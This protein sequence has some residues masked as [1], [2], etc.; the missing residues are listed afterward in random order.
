MPLEYNKLISFPSWDD[1][2]LSSSLLFLFLGLVT[3]L[4]D[5]TDKLGQSGNSQTCLGF[6]FAHA[7]RWWRSQTSFDHFKIMCSRLLV[8][9]SFCLCELLHG[10][11]DF[12]E[13]SSAETERNPQS[14]QLPGKASRG[15]FSNESTK[16]SPCLNLQ[17]MLG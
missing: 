5:C 2:T 1:N 17:A 7:L 11:W 4:A 15:Y 6:P 12:S 3:I 10:A 13:S 16:Y 14:R 8:S 9:W